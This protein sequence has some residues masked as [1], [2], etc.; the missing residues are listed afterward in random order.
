[1]SI[2]EAPAPT[3][4]GQVTAEDMRGN[5]RLTRTVLALVAK[6]C[7]FSKG[8]FTVENV[9]D[10]LLDGSMQLWGVMRPPASL[11]AVLVTRKSNDAFEILIVGPEIDDTLQYLPRLCAI[12]Q[13]RGCKRALMVG[14]NMWRSKL[15]SDWRRSAV[16]YERTLDDAG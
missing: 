13:A 16:V 6:V 2:A 1:M 5:E 3:I 7:G 8:R 11:E 15:P 4:F 10:G 12:G 14:P 9:A